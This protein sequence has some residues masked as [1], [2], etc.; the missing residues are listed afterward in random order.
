MAMRAPESMRIIPGTLEWR[1]GI[2]GKEND[3]WGI[4][5]EN[6]GTSANILPTNKKGGKLFKFNIQIDTFKLGWS[7]CLLVS[8]H[9]QTL[10]G[11]LW[12]S[13]CHTHTH[14][15][16]LIHIGH[17]TSLHFAFREL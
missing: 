9:I 12:R 16:T 6:I 2:S 10:G 15:L 14:T 11:V 4:Q 3:V 17:Q 5:E 1:V 7:V 13:E 8:R